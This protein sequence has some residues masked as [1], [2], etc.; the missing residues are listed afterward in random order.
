[1][2]YF[3]LFMGVLKVNHVQ[4][5]DVCTITESWSRFTFWLSSRLLL[6]SIKNDER[7]AT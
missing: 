3:Y 1:M 5:T 4:R 6:S 7:W 2:L